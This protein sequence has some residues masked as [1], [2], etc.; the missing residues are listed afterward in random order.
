MAAEQGNDDEGVAQLRH[1]TAT[2]E[3]QPPVTAAATGPTGSRPW[4]RE[5]VAL[6][7]RQHFAAVPLREFE[8]EVASHTSPSSWVA[9]EE[10]QT[11][12]VQWLFVQPALPTPATSYRRL[13]LKRFLDLCDRKGILTVEHIYEIYC[14]L[15]EASDNDT[16]DGQQADTD[17]ALSNSSVSSPCAPP[18][19]TFKSYGV[20]QDADPSNGEGAWVTVCES[21]SLA[22]HGTTGLRMWE[23]GMALTEWLVRNR[24]DVVDGKRVLELGSGVG[25]TGMAVAQATAATSVTL[26]DGSPKVIEALCRNVKLT[27]R[28][29]SLLAL[30]RTAQS[31][32]AQP[33]AKA[34]P[35]GGSLPSHAGGSWHGMDVRLLDWVD[36]D[37]STLPEVDVVVGADLTF[38]P[39]ALAGLVN[40]VHTLLKKMTGH[41]SGGG[42]RVDVEGQ[43][44]RKGCGGADACGGVNGCGGVDAGPTPPPSPPC[45]W[46]CSAIRN[47]GTYAQFL[48]LL[49]DAGLHHT[50]V[51]LECDKQSLLFWNRSA[52]IVL[53]K[54][55]LT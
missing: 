27:A 42:G 52:D 28:R 22:S 4:W 11:A 46:L 33:E 2:C 51:P 16:D 31:Q 21:L 37:A 24:R 54:I 20:S 55:T 15:L 5:A 1:S 19:C 44:G 9:E 38:F 10:A 34:G 50:T 7:C 3:L 48:G 23:A 53:L 6:V 36:F 13:F 39:D 26:T 18:G 8:W 17:D 25:L 49:D 30:K 14:E 35:E 47:P 43:Q 32:W 40:V 45:A 41:G 12:M 29:P